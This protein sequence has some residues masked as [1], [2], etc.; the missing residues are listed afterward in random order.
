MCYNGGM[1]TNATQ[2]DPVALRDQL[3]DEVANGRDLFSRAF[4]E[5]GLALLAEVT[6]RPKGVIE[7]EIEQAAYFQQRDEHGS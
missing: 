6:H 4:Y 7:A 1:E 3:V 2:V 5:E